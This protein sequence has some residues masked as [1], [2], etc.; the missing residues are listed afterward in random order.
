[1]RGAFAANFAERGEV[2]AAVHVVARGEVVVDLV[3]GW[4]DEDRTRPWR[5][6]TLVDVYSAGKGLLAVLALRLVDAGLL[7]LDQPVADVWPDFAAEGK[8]SATLTHVLTHRA[9]V[10]AIREILT[11][12][13]LF[14]WERMT[15]AIAATPAWWAPGER[16]AYHTNTFGHLVGEVV[17]RASGAMPGAALREIA[18]DVGADA[19]FGVPPEEQH[20]CADVVW[21]LPL[22]APTV[23]DVDGLEGDRLMDVLAHF[24]PPGYSSIG[25]VNT[26][27]WR[28]TPLG[29]TAGHASASGLARIYAALLE[30][31]R[32]VSPDLLDRASRPQASGH[33]PIL[34]DDVVFGLGFQPTT[35]RR[36]LGPNPRSFGHFGTGGALGFADPDAGVAFGYVMNHV[37]P[38]WQSTR[39]RSLV[40]ALYASLADR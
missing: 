26:P 2:G 1:V 6:D 40:D 25:L 17:H 37:I 9:G 19:W 24:N 20:R 4:T 15:E 27:A 21:G 22:Q 3:G 30:P 13:D 16:L 10:P 29:S 5:H 33:C 34:D 39:N 28:A 12:E 8:A 14:D 35:A 36:P 38:R 7:G 32:L 23:L 18:A 31:G 11:D